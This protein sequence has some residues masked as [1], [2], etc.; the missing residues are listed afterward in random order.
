MKRKNVSRRRVLQGMSGALGTAALGCGSDNP[1]TPVVP[2][3]GGSGGQGGMNQGAGGAGGQGMGSGGQGGA[4]A[5]DPC[6]DGS[7]YS[8]EELLAPIEN[9]VVL[10]MENRSFDHYLG[11]LQMLEGKEVLGLLGN[12]SNPDP[13]GNIIQVFNLMNFTP[14]DPPHDW[15]ACHAQFNGGKNDGFV[16]AH[17]GDSQ[18]D[19]MGY[20]VRSQIPIT[21]ALSDAAAICH[22]YFA[23]VMGPTWPNRF[24][25]H[26]G[27][28][29]GQKSNLPEF[30]F[31]SIWDLLED[32][33]IPAKNYYHDIAWC[34]GAFFKVGGT[35]G[36]EEFFADAAAGTLPPFSIIDPQFF[37][38]GAN[39]DHPDHD[40]Q[41]GQAL[42]SSVFTALAKSPQWDKCLFVLTYD[43]HGGFFDH[44]VPPKTV[45]DDPEF[46]QMGFRVPTLVAGPF[47]KRGCAINTVLEHSSIVK[48]VCQRFKLP[49]LNKRVQAANDLSSVIAPMYFG[50]PQPPPV[51]PMLKLS[52]QKI[53]SRPL[54]TGHH[55]EMW[56][57]AE[58][59][60]IPKALDRRSMGLGSMES[61]LAWGEKLGA[62][63]LLK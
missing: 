48:T 36:I 5:A 31:D 60:V 35:A 3:N 63:R 14:A 52:K 16:I 42:I 53:L 38:A 33:K 13:N 40:I 43:E 34:S 59:R 17:A 29:Q 41:L 57:A 49:Y 1:T 56:E 44:I 11:A 26:G 15:D 51:M 30:G 8:P 9:I 62:I 24:Y 58:K 55:Q 4:S 10:C 39:D 2:I 32:A 6:M 37:G 21:Y 54:R 20:H 27:T 61:V 45:D 19:V 22:R 46:E 28:S 18:N 23:S 25:L 7:G 50:K 47:V 12:E